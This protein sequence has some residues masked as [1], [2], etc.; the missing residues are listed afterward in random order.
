MGQE[1]FFED[2][3]DGLRKAKVMV[4]FV[5]DEYAMSKNCKMEFRFA[6]STLK[7]PTVLAVVG[8][9]YAWERTEVGLLTVGHSQTCPKVNLQYE[10]EAGLLDLLKA[11]QDFLPK[12]TER[13]A[14]DK[15][16]PAHQQAIAFQEVL[17]LTQRKLL[18]H[19][20]MYSETM[21]IEPFPRLVLVD[22]K[23]D[24]K[25]TEKRNTKSA[26]V[27]E[28]TDGR[29]E[30]G[31]RGDNPQAEEKNDK[32]CLRLLCEYEQGWHE[33]S[34]P[35]SMPRLEGAALEEFL[36]E[37]AA[38]Q[39]RVLAIL[40]HSNLQLPVL[41]T[42]AGDQLRRKMEEWCA[43]TTSEF[44]EEYQ[45]MLQMALDQ[46][47]QRTY[48]GLKRCHMPNGKILW[49]C[50][51]HEGCSLTHTEEKY[52][53]QLKTNDDIDPTSENFDV[54]STTVSDDADRFSMVSRSNSVASLLIRPEDPPEP[55]Q[56]QVKVKV[57][58]AA[59]GAGPLPRRP[60]PQRRNTSG[61]RKT[62]SQA[63]RL[64]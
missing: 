45:K 6:V 42:P 7:I 48:G 29:Q 34:Q 11:V 43:R 30:G 14:S 9:G 54:E 37:V 61:G 63:C 56:P 44:Q 4:A 13:G 64:M 27:R 19:I 38:Y 55:E 36:K 39:A 25:K 1:G 40:K 53:D 8:T 3:A 17:E 10:N 51:R 49:L 41:T 26:K 24:D 62:T 32:Y 2:L 35:I 20:S 18:R 60:K 50:D 59:A 58:P 12:S 31:E 23:D 46:D 21:D 52:K 15:T 5:S 57:A 33:S 16:S 28:T 47:E 22:I